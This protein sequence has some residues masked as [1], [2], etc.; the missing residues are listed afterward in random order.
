MMVA[1][2][3]VSRMSLVRYS[4]PAAPADSVLSM[5]PMTVAS[6]KGTASGR[7]GSVASTASIH[8][9][10]GHG[11]ASPGTATRM[12]GGD[13]PAP[14]TVAISQR[15][16]KMAL[17]SSTEERT[18]GTPRGSLQ[19]PISVNMTKVSDTMPMSGSHKT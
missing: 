17:P 4:S 11:S 5:P 8:A 7:Y 2:A 10:V 13:A 3:S 15:P 16:Q 14:H 12:A 6:A 19:P 9:R 1:T 18:T